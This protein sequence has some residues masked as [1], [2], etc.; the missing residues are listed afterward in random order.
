MRCGFGI[1]RT[2]PSGRVF[3]C[4]G[5]TL[6]ELIV[7]ITILGVI[8]VV[9]GSRFFSTSQFSAM[10][11]ADVAANGARYAQKL[12]LSSGCDTRVQVT[13]SALHLWQRADSC[14]SGAFTRPVT[15]PGGDIWQ[16]SIPGGVS[17]TAL[18]IYFDSRG[19]P[20]AHASAAALTAPVTVSVGSRT[21]TIEPETGYVQQ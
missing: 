6:V 13:A 8:A 4:A 2:R 17:V 20:Y 15:R 14:T 9:A 5:F 19:R 3:A 21:V 1:H 16:E 18:D 11:F 7:A 12:A 10:G